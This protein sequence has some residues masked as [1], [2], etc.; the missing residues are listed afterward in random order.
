MKQTVNLETRYVCHCARVTPEDFEKI[1][2]ESESPNLRELKDRH[3][4]VGQC[5][6]CEYEVK[7]LLE[8]HLAERV[9]KKKEEKTK[10]L[11]KKN[12]WEQISKNVRAMFARQAKPQLETYR[13]GVFF[14]RKDGLE[15]HLVVSNLQFP[16]SEKNPNGDHV[17]FHVTLYG[18]EGAQLARSRDIRLP[19][20]GTL[21]CTPADLFP[22]LDSDVVGAM[23]IDFDNV[24]QT[25]SL[26]PYGLLVNTD[27]TSRARCHYH[28]KFALFTD[29]GFFQNSSP[30]EPG[31]TC[32]MALSNCQPKVYESDYHVQFSGK[33][34]SG[35]IRVEPMASRWVRLR[36]L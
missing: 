18:E 29:P 24:A 16:E 25:G 2:A 13:T 7:G 5:T 11:P 35:H 31:Q 3:G 9:L 1:L 12:R 6:S 33:K 20:N 23:Y 30:F 21:E 14:L 36:D 19:N 32:W 15:S 17:D 22:E 34:F 4:I 8:E 27:S 10:K 26:R 28:D